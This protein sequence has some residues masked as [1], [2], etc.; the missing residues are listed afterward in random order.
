MK[1]LINRGAP[2]RPDDFAAKLDF[3]QHQLMNPESLQ[4]P[5]LS[6]QVGV[7]IGKNKALLTQGYNSPMGLYSS[8]NIADTLVTSMKGLVTL[9]I[10]D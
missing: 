6:P 8:Q 10:I 9:L 1:I 4:Q 2:P 7:Q 5:A 3:P